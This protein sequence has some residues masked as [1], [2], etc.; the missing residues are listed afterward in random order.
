MAALYATV[1][2]APPT[3]TVTLDSDDDASPAL[4]LA[5]YTPVIGD[6]VAALPLGGQ[7]LVLGKV[8]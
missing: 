3:L 7:L 8:V 1:T 4:L 5:G 2:T 6:R